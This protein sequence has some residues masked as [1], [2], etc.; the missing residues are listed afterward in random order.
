MRLRKVCFVL[1]CFVITASMP[2]MVAQQQEVTVQ[3]LIFDLEHPDADRRKKAAETIGQHKLRAAVPALIKAAAD[4]DDSVRLAAVRALVGIND[5]RALRAYIDLTDDLIR[6]IQKKSIE[7][8]INLYVVEDSGFIYGLRKFAEFVNPFSDDYNPLIVEPYIDVSPEAIEAIARLLTAPDKGVREDAATALGILRGH[9]AL[10]ALQKALAAESN[11]DVKVELVRAIYK[12]GDAAAGG[13]LVPLI[14]DPEKKVHDEAILTVGRLR[15]QEAVPALKSLYESGTAERRKFLKIVPISGSDD[16]EK[17]L[18]EALAYIGDPGC[19]EIFLAALEDER[20]EVRRYG[21]E[22][23]GRAGDATVI[24]RVARKYLREKSAAARLAMSFALYRL[25]R[26]EHLL[27]LIDN[28]TSGDQ[29]FYYMLEFSPQEVA[30]LYSHIRVEPAAVKIRLLEVAGL[31]GDESA[32]PLFEQMTQSE[33]VDVV[34]A[35]NL[36]IRRV[37]GRYDLL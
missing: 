26:E 7:G 33:N 3:G 9:A 15:V 2:W 17:K 4:A 14:N 11:G 34:S 20:E 8:I 36:G 29:A 32:L 16:L 24:T 31:K 21:A 19:K 1:L 35:A 25:G 28:L 5:R 30:G 13:T 37:R 23:L 18:L 12:I 27:E 6:D 22:G 10:P